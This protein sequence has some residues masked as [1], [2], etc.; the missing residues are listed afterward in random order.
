MRNRP[1]AAQVIGKLQE[2][3]RH[4]T[5]DPELVPTDRM[6]QR[7]AVSVGSGL[8]QDVE[9]WDDKPISKPPP[10]DDETAITVDRIVQQLGE[11][12]RRLAVS[13]YKSA[14]PRQSIAYELAIPRSSMYL[15]WRAMLWYLRGRFQGAGL[16]C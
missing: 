6:M 13:W 15:E 7:W 4:N 9:G 12:Y 1:S 11:K 16:D 3:T 8:P 2:A 10:L 14:K 5:L